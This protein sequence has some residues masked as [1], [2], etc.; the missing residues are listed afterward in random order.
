M[1]KIL[2]V[3]FLISAQIGAF[4]LKSHSQLPSVKFTCPSTIGGFHDRDTILLADETTLK[5]GKTE[6]KIEC[7]NE[8]V[9]NEIFKTHGTLFKRFSCTWKKDRHGRYKHYV[10][11][12][13]NGDAQIILSWAK[14]NL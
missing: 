11:Y 13:S 4:Y 14:S 3:A 9:F 5:Y 10:A 2:I 1:K 6:A 8:K 7:D 12:L